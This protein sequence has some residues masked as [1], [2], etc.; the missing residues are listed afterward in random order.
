MFGESTVN[1][2]TEIE[3]DDEMINYPALTVYFGKKDE[4]VWNI[5]KNFSS[6]IDM[7]KQEN[8]IQNDV[9]DSN[10]ILIIPGI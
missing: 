4:T 8:D 1:V 2:L 6:D 3:A 9:L 7:I 5:A 10:K